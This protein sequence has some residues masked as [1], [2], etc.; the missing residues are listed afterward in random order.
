MGRWKEDDQRSEHTFTAG[1][2]HMCL[3]KGPFAC[4]MIDDLN[5]NQIA[6]YSLP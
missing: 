6:K 1:R 5:R 4:S 2:I 3:E